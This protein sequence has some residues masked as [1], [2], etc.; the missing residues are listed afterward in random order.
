LKILHLYKDYYPV[1]GGIEGHIQSLAEA[2]AAAGHQVTVLVTNPDG[3]R[4]EEELNG[5]RVVRLP[6]LGTAISTPL[7]LGFIPFLRKEKPEITHLHFPYP[8]A[9]LSQ[10]VAG[11]GR[12]YVISYHSDIIRPRQQLF[13][14][15]YRPLLWRVLR[16]A[17]RILVASPSY[18][19]TSPFLQVVAD[20]CVRVP[21]GID[22]LPF[23][24]ASPRYA[25]G[26]RARIFFHGRHRYYKGV[27]VLLQAM[28]QVEAD[29]WI[30]GDGEMRGEW[31]ALAAELGLKDKVRFFG[32]IA[33]RE[34]P[35]MYASVDLFVLPSTL[36]AEAFGIVLLEAMAA[37][38]PCVTTELGTGTSFIV[39]DGLTGLVVP[40]GEPSA[41]AEAM[42]RLLDDPDLRAR[43]GAKGRARVMG[44]F[45][46]ERMAER[47]AAVYQQAFFSLPR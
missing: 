22:P 12:P 8:V 28:T 32:D 40:P 20:K 21:Y 38:L 6:R 2:Q 23:L 27:E 25:K 15:F 31:A 37:G 43:M 14:R 13:L 35:G 9:E 1:L 16:G 33:R 24:K 47:V 46:V 7:T 3:Q 26:G 10:L 4:S 5:V 42:R 34:L 11:R 30:G 18:S 17:R 29:L 19:K 39:Q 45:T 44:E 36:R 41:L